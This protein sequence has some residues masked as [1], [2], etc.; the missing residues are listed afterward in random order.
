MLTNRQREHPCPATG[1]LLPA[2]GAGRP[3]RLFGKGIHSNHRGQLW[4]GHNFLFAGQRGFRCVF[5]SGGEKYQNI[6]QHRRNPLNPHIHK[7]HN[8]RIHKHTHKDVLTDT[9]ICTHIQTQDTHTHKHRDTHTQD[10][11]RHANRYAHTYRQKH[12]G[13]TH[14]HKTHT[15]TCTQTHKHMYAHTDT[16]THTWQIP[17][18]PEQLLFRLFPLEI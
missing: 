7:T 16:N 1:Q 18:Q 10:A 12:T 15:Q 8:T 2:D 3:R 5:P 14:K 11:L 6:R 4:A 9:H 17:L 13:S